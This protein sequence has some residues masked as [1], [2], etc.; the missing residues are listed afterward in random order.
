MESDPGLGDRN[1][2]AP[3]D[4]GCEVWKGGAG[5]G[6]GENP[7]DMNG[8]QLG[9]SSALRDTLEVNVE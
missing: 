6:A 4:G 9:L 5:E 3:G 1:D 7:G 8:L 2:S